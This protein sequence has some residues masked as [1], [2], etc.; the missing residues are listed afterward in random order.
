[1]PSP[2][3]HAH[4]LSPS[5]EATQTVQSFHGAA[6]TLGSA[7]RDKEIKKLNEEIERLKNKI[8]GESFQVKLLSFCSRALIAA[9]KIFRVLFIRWQSRRQSLLNFSKPA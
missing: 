9:K 4:T 6:R 1:M 8:A 5:P 3:A 7:A 2:R